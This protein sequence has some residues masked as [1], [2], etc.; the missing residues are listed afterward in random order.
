MYDWKKTRLQRLDYARAEHPAT[1]SI[2]TF[3]V[4]LHTKLQQM[5]IFDHSELR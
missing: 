1:S 4:H 3:S 5:F 2:S